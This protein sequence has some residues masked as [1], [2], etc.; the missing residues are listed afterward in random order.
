MLTLYSL[1]KTCLLLCSMVLIGIHE[2]KAQAPQKI[3]I[4]ASNGEINS[5]IRKQAYYYPN[6][7]D[8][9]VIFLSGISNAGNLNYNMLSGEVEF[10]DKRNDTLELANMYTV[11]MVTISTDSFYYDQK[12]KQLLKLLADYTNTK[13]LVKEMYELSNIKSIGA[14]GRETN[15]NAPSSSRDLQFNTQNKLKQNES[16]VFSSKPTY[17]FSNHNSFLPANKSNALRLFPNH[18][19][20][21]KNYIE[22]NKVNFK[23]EEE[24]KQLLQFAASL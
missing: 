10:I 14:M 18:K 12:N 11:A 19:A 22:K 5:S 7:Q 21:V 9:K 4:K 24:I 1:S 8:G 3:K 17:Y 20:A 13:L 6:F 2:S 16:M 15:S 23:K